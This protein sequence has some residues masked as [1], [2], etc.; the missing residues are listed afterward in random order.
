MFCPTT[1]SPNAFVLPSLQNGMLQMSVL[2]SQNLRILEHRVV[3][4]TGS[5]M[6]AE[7]LCV[8][9]CLPGSMIGQTRLPRP[10]KRREN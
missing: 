9:R 7:M 6:R 1:S 5:F 4:Q 2:L 3:N 8:L 10:L